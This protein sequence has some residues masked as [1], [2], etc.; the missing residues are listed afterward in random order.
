MAEKAN[1]AANTFKPLALKEGKCR[2]SI[3]QIVANKGQQ[4]GQKLLQKSR[5]SLCHHRLQSCSSLHATKSQINYACSISSSSNNN[6]APK[7][8]Q[9]RSCCCCCIFFW[10]SAALNSRPTHT[11]LG[12]RPPSLLPLT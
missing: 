8:Q 2:P 6:K 3:W 1:K 11:P 9:H 12:S 10:L 7:V 4:Q 5:Q